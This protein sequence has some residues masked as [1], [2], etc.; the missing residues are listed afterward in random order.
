MQI[1]TVVIVIGLLATAGA[2][3]AE[4]GKQ[5]PIEVIVQLSTK[6]GELAITPSDLRLQTGKR[7]RLVINNPSNSTHY[8]SVPR[9]GSAVWTAKIDVQG[10]VVNRTG[11]QNPKRA[12]LARSAAT[13]SYKV[14]EIEL[15]P[16]GMAQWTFTPVQGRAACRDQ[17]LAGAARSFVALSG[18]AR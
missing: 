11:F 6:S 5:K 15:R 13:F 17:A 7:Y 12:I 3:A 18:A 1:L 8:L 9:F 2:Q 10:G 16:G 4:L 14:Q